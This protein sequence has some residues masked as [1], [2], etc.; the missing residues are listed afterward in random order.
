MA[1]LGKLKVPEIGEPNPAGVTNAN[2]VGLWVALPGEEPQ[3]LLRE[4]DV[5]EGKRVRCFIALTAISSSS[6]QRRTF[7][8]D[9][10]ALLI[11]VNAT[12]GHSI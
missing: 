12:D 3:L 6:A 5:I 7:T 2:D 1:F 11:R 9:G 8:S 10:R 4:G